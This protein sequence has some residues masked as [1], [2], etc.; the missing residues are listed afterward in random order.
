MLSKVMWGMS[1]D[2]NLHFLWAKRCHKMQKPHNILFVSN[3]PKSHLGVSNDPK[4]HFVS[5]KN[6]KNCL[7]QNGEKCVRAV[8][9]IWAIYII[10]NNYRPY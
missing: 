5:A 6:A 7:K 8:L 9:L 4:V 10:Q 2:Q 1:N 3:A